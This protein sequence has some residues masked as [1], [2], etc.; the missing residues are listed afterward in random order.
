M[1]EDVKWP[2]IPDYIVASQSTIWHAGKCMF[3]LLTRGRF[4][5]EEHNCLN[6]KDGVMKFGHYKANV[7][8]KKYSKTLIATVL[9]C[10]AYARRPNQQNLLSRFEKVFSVYDNTYVAPAED[11]DAD[12]PY[13]T[14]N[15]LIPEG[16][17]KAEGAVY[18]RLLKVVEQRRNGGPTAPHIIT[19]TDL[20]KDYDDL[21]AMLCLKE[22]HRLN[23][24]TL[25]G[26]V[27]NLA[28]ADRR[29]LFGRGALDSLTLQHMPIGIGTRGSS[30][31]ESELKHEFDNTDAFMASESRLSECPDGQ[32]LLKDVFTKA[33]KENRKVS[34]LALSS[35]MDIAQFSKEE[36]ELLKQGLADVTLQGGYSVIKNVLTVDETAA[37]NSFDLEGAYTFHKFIAEN[38][39]PSRVWT[40]VAAFKTP[41]DST[42]FQFLEETKHPLGPYLRQ[43]QIAQDTNFYNGTYNKIPFAYHMTPEWYVENKSTWIQ[44]GHEWD[45]EFPRGEAMVPYFTKV[46]AYDALAAVG[47]SGEDV[48]EEFGLI[49]P[50]VSRKDQEL[51]IHKVAGI[52]GSSPDAK[53]ILPEE[54]NIDADLLGVMC[55]AL[56]KGA[57]L[58]VNQKLGD[59]RGEEILG[60]V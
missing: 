28:P 59:N 40:R 58:S 24:V 5:D 8:Q 26:F 36:P 43:V 55:E 13:V 31:D 23:V 30:L 15:S 51:S 54:C 6:V 56:M 33:I 48:L 25:E 39:I 35:L 12:E 38:K 3:N 37:N 49:K 27:A 19:I 22:L 1:P 50:A 47:A 2:G 16:L 44:A 14:R 52:S 18:E 4:W 29:A 53:P 57:L 10:L 34:Y 11:L 41:I 21:V 45:E 42:T 7:L 9:G 60:D 17:S 46:T 32:Q 20:A